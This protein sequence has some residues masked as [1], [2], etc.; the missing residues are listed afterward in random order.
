[1]FPPMKFGRRFLALK[2]EP[3]RRLT[4][5][6]STVSVALGCC[7][8][9]SA[10]LW[11]STRLFPLAPVSHSL[12]AIRFPLDYVCFACLL[13]LLLT[14]SIAARPRKLVL[15]FVCLA[16]ALSLWDQNR[17]QPWFFQNVC[18]LGALAF[19]AWRKPE[20]ENNRAALNV[21][22]LIIICGY[23]WSGLQKLN[24]NFVRQTWP[25][26]TSF[27]PHFWQSVVNGFPSWIIVIIPLTEI[28]IGIGLLT[29]RFRDAAVLLAITIHVLILSLLIA[30]GENTVVWP[31]NLAMIL[32]AFMLFWQD[33]QTGAAEILFRKNA[34]HALVVILFGALP[35]LSFINLWD[36]YL[37]AALYSGNTRQAVIYVT[38]A[39]INLLPPTTCRH[40]WQSTEPF[41]LDVNRWAFGE[42]NVPVY[43]EARV[44]RT[45]A[46]E[47]CRY[48]KNDSGVRLRI[49]SR[50]DPFSGRR[51]SEDYDCEHLH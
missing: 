1:M 41:F 29:L 35:A 46:E 10:K 13:A 34:F 21:C 22:R 37:S 27:L 12:P 43:P 19:L 40:I 32:F 20:A 26:M 31:W 7:L 9:L 30:S 18:I 11:V 4:W 2:I 33:K 36:S 44:Y 16:T 5:L 3:D 8:V 25:E 6:K 47:I 49:K 42:L 39:V 50:P 24:V 28:F 38:P 15:A 17:W 51:Q 45:V 48:A 14:I 23:F